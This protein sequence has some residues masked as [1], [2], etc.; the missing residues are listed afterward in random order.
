MRDFFLFLIINC[1]GIASY[2]Y[3]FNKNNKVTI[4]SFAQTDNSYNTTGTQTDITITEMVKMIQYKE[5]IDS[6]YDGNKIYEW[7]FV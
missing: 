6:I 3:F 1:T 4:N 5:E 7:K 2:K